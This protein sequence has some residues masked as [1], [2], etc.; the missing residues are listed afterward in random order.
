MKIYESGVLSKIN[1]EAHVSLDT[2]TGPGYPGIVRVQMRTQGSTPPVSLDTSFE[3]DTAIEFANLLI[4]CAICAKGNIA[5]ANPLV[6]PDF[7]SN[8]LHCSYCHI[9]GVE[10]CPV[11]GNEKEA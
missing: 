10:A 6:Q 9:G 1:Q 5:P 8:D 2:W 11:H 4:E 3:P 7:D